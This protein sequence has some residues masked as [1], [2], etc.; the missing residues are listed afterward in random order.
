MGQESK[1][2]NITPAQ[3]PDEVVE[4]AAEA[5]AVMDWD[6][7]LPHEQERHLINFPTST[8]GGGVVCIFS[9]PSSLVMACH[10]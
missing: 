5:M 6:G 7:L 4:V 10:C 1:L 2:M 3:I 8:P 9:I